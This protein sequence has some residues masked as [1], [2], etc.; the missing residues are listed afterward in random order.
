[1]SRGC[2]KIRELAGAVKTLYRALAVKHGLY[3]AARSR[4][5]MQKIGFL[6]APKIITLF[7]IAFI[8]AKL[9]KRCE[10]YLKRVRSINY[11]VLF[12]IAIY[13]YRQIIHG[14]ADYETK[15]KSII[16]VCPDY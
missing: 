11:I 4:K 6:E 2:E 8:K 5:R 12:N 7:I 15:L 13:L 3:Y 16:S 14:F 10:N 1:M 9:Y